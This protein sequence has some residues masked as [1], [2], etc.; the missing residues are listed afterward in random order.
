VP[1]AVAPWPLGYTTAFYGVVSTLLGAGFIY[2]AWKVL[3]MSDAD[4]T[5]KPAKA[6]FGY[7]LLYLFVI[8]A[9]YLA[10][11]VYERAAGL[12]VG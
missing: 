11:S 1:V 7:S 5:M 4:R 9:A 12:V 10:D 8:F 6:M 3:R 2:Y